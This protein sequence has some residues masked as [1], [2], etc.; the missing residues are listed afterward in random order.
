MLQNAT[1]LRK[2]AP[3]P[4][5]ISDEDLLYC[6]CHAK[7]IFPDPLQMSHTCHRFWTCYKTFTFCSLG[8]AQNPLRLPR[9]T[10]SEPSKV[11]RAC[12]AF[13]MLTWKRALRHNRARFFDISTSKSAPGP[14]VFN[15]F[16]LE[17]CFVPQR[18]ARFQH[19]NFQKCSERKV[20]VAFSLSNVLRATTACTFST[21]QL[22]KVLRSW[23]VLYML[24]S[25]CASRHNG[26]QFFIPHLARWLRTRRFSET[27]FRLSGATNHWKNAVFRDFPTFSRT[28]IFFLLLFSSLLW[29]FSSLLSICPYCRK[30]DF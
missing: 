6:A 28:C 27:T 29:L 18:R 10:T 17:M 14:S 4:P 19:L 13:N 16:D 8:T 9:K 2:S 7:C 15:A 26:T 3:W 1:P 30:F 20:L 23:G 24:A 25:T 12:S 11:V 5:S 22:L 21:S